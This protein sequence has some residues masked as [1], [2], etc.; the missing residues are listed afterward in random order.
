MRGRMS[1]KIILLF[2]QLTTFNSVI[3]HSKA[4]FHLSKCTTLYPK[5]VLWHNK[6]RQFFTFQNVLLCTQNKCPGTKSKGIFFT[7]QNVLLC[8]QDKFFGTISKGKFSPFKMCYFAP[9]TSALVPKASAS[10]IKP[11]VP[12]EKSCFVMMLDSDST[13]FLILTVLY[14]F[15]YQMSF[16]FQNYPKNLDPSYKMDLDLWIV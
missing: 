13:V 15:G 16:S 8:T 2:S 7:F 11:D 14:F 1:S 10:N 5:Q 9:K 12:I 3:R 6:Q 4:V